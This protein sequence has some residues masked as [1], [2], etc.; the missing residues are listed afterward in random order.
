MYRDIVLLL[1]S[2]LEWIDFGEFTGLLLVCPQG[3]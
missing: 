3:W 2:L 1:L